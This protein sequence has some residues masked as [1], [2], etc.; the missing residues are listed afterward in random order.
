MLGVHHVEFFSLISMVCFFAIRPGFLRNV[1]ENP[2]TQ[3]TG[4]Q[5]KGHTR[6][7]FFSR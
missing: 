1:V 3:F 6:A 4:H 7:S 2:F 5:L